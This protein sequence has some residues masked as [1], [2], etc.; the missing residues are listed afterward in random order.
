MRYWKN[1]SQATKLL[2]PTERTELMVAPRLHLQMILAGQL[3]LE[4]LHSVA[5]VFNIASAL[6]NYRHRRELEESFG[7]SQLI[8]AN[9]I[10]EL[11]L[12]TD[13]ETLQVTSSFNAADRLIS[14]QNKT[15]LAKVI[16][17]VDRRIARGDVVKPKSN[18]GAKA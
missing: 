1:R 3:D 14:S 13:N 6:A 10:Q 8:M 17:Y 16:T 9:L 7:R 11:R 12:P 4:Y 2:K 18:Q 5:G 15:D